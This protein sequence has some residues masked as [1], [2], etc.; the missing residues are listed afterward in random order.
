MTEARPRS[1]RPRN[2]KQQIIAAASEQF[3]TSGF[4]NVGIS[5]IAEAVGISGPALYRH[6]RGKQELLQATLVDAIDKN[7]EP[8]L[9]DFRDLRG[10]L[11]AVAVAML[12]R[13]HTGVLWEREL[14]H[15]PQEQRHELRARYVATIEPLRSAIATSRPELSADLVELLLRAVM[16]VF[17]TMSQHAGKVEPARARLLMTDLA[18]TICEF[19]GLEPREEGTEG[20]LRPVPYRRLLPVSRREA[21]LT[22]ATRLFAERGYE[23]VGMED[24][25]TAAAGMA[26]PSLY[27]HFAGKSAIL[28]AAL[29]RCLE[30]MLFDLS[31]AL[32]YAEEP[33]QALDAALHSFVRISIQHGDAMR[34][35]LHEIVNVP[36]EE[37]QAVRRMQHD[38][39][40]EW[41]ALLIGHRP[42]LFPAEAELLVHATHSVV[43]TL[44]QNGEIWAR[45]ALRDEIVTLGRAVL[46]LP[47]DVPSSD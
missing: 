19:R 32:E 34:A 47:A 38:Y 18:L 23:A 3:R 37:R 9:G 26:G 46:G 29:T 39:V 41:T 33:G 4:H 15:L 22:V 43:S 1:T 25:A 8:F 27:H 35:L 44:S 10:M 12:D 28:V 24:I 42:E 14:A 30:A 20:G 5:D 13:R 2:R 36:A 11:D 17:A 45:P 7:T 31:A 16:A 6:F 21:V 40:A